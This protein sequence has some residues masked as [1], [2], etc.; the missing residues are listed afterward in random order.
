MSQSRRARWQESVRARR[1]KER[2]LA[3]SQHDALHAQSRMARAKMSQSK[4]RACEIMQGTAPRSFACIAGAHTGRWGWRRGAEPRRGTTSFGFRQG[5]S[6]NLNWGVPQWTGECTKLLFLILYI[7]AAVFSSQ[8]SV[9]TKSTDD[10]S[11]QLY[12][13][14]RQV[15][16]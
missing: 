3:L 15:P 10:Q 7:R 5:A 13:R 4:N 14:Y 8:V 16:N 12:I 2:Q 11:T 1:C 6:L 9:V